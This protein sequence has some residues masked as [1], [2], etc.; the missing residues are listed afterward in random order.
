MEI[1]CSYSN[2]LMQQLPHPEGGNG[3]V[4]ETVYKTVT[5]Y[6]DQA[7]QEVKDGFSR[8]VREIGQIGNGDLELTIRSEADFEKAQPLIQQSYE[9]G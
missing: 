1:V 7:N 6:L 2:W 5:E 3:G 4:G 8:D 9:S